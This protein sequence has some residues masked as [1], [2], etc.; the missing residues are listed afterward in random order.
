MKAARTAS[1]WDCGSWPCSAVAPV[2][3][4]SGARP[5]PFALGFDVA[6]ELAPASNGSD[7][8]AVAEVAVACAQGVEQSRVKSR[9]SS[10]VTKQ[11]ML[12]LRLSCTELGD[13]SFISAINEL[14]IHHSIRR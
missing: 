5:L 4:G 14:A 9:I 10:D 3:G 2:S 6:F 1:R 12:V 8:E 11:Q 7:V 13:P